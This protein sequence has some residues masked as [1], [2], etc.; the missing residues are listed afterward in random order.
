MNFTVYYIFNQINL[1]FTGTIQMDTTNITDPEIVFVNQNGQTITSDYLS[2]TIQSDLCYTMSITPDS[3]LNFSNTFVSFTYLNNDVA[4][5]KNLASL[6]S[7]IKFLGNN[8]SLH[9]VILNVNFTADDSLEAELE[10]DFKTIIYF[11]PMLGSADPTDYYYSVVEENGGALVERIYKYGYPFKPL[12]DYTLAENQTFRFDYNT[13]GVRGYLYDR[14][15]STFYLNVNNV[16]HNAFSSYNWT[17][18]IIISKTNRQYKIFEYWN[19]D[20]VDS[21]GGNYF[22]KHDNDFFDYLFYCEEA[23]L[24]ENNYCYTEAGTD[25]I[26]RVFD[27]KNLYLY[28]DLETTKRFM[29]IELKYYTT[30]DPNYPENSIEYTGNLEDLEQDIYCVYTLAMSK[31]ESMNYEYTYYDESFGFKYGEDYAANTFEFGSCSSSEAYG[32]VVDGSLINQTDSGNYKHL[33]VYIPDG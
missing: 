18:N 25:R 5:Y 3:S 30:Y 33:S 31:S 12:S 7:F 9:T 27:K 16:L 14:I 24:Y 6:D 19:C 32:D 23:G 10:E 26:P 22:E 13:L 20:L 17:V 1:S 11:Y 8:D 29:I 15:N 2:C 21:M 4:E 28:N